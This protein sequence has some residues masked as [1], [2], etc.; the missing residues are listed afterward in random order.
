MYSS[1]LSVNDISRAVRCLFLR[2]P[3]SLVA[4][5]VDENLRSSSQRDKTT[6]IFIRK[7]AFANVGGNL[8][9]TCRSTTAT[10]EIHHYFPEVPHNRS[11]RHAILNQISDF[12]EGR[13]SYRI[14]HPTA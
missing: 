10:I 12:K 13:N 6:V 1:G 8:N 2:H 7:R 14:N 4:L 9:I 5:T 3:V 11:L